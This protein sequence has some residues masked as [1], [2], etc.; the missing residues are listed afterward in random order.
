MRKKNMAWLAIAVA[1]PSAMALSSLAAISSINPGPSNL[2]AFM[3]A[4][5]RMRAMLP[6]ITMLR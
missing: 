5:P 3:P 1:V 4:M 2:P 6:Q